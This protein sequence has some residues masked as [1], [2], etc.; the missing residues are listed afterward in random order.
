MKTKDSLTEH[1]APLLEGTYDC[2]DRIVLN[3]Y[4]PMLL[5]TG[6]VRNWYRVMEGDDK[7]MSDATMMRYAGRFSRRVQA[8]CKK[9]NIPFIHF[10]TGKRKHGEAKK[11]LPKDKSFIGIF[12]VF[13]SHHIIVRW[14]YITLK[15]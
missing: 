13:V 5:V 4:C 15:I 10:Q 11:L 7:D 9:K 3:A 8:F 12:A 2:I 14:L 1:Y 6:G